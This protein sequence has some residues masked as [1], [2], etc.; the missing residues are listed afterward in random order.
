M[1]WSRSRNK[2]A[3]PA[4][5]VVH[6]IF[7]KAHAHTGVGCFFLLE[8]GPLKDRKITENLLLR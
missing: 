2:N 3:D 1:E 8:T 6:L 5:L 7:F 4:V